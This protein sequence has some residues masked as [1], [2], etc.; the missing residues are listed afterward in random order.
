MNIHEGLGRHW[1]A[2][3]WGLMILILTGIPGQMIPK[4]TGFMDMFAPDKI[5]HLVIFGGF[6][7][8]LIRGFIAE[9]GYSFQKSAVVSIIISTML[10]ALTEI[11][12]WLVFINRQASIWDFIVDVVGIILGYLICRRWQA[13]FLH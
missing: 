8:V 4:V 2:I 7:I 10:G 3:C 13:F 6:I 1:L 5:V 9:P 12:Q 11:L